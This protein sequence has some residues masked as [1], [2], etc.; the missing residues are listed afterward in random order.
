MTCSEYLFATLSGILGFFVGLSELANRYKSFRLLLLDKYSWLYMM[1]NFFGGFIVYIIVIQ[2][3]LPIGSLK[4]HHIGRV[5]FCGLSAMAIL[6][7]SFF[8]YKDANGKTFEVGPAALLTIFSKVAEIQFDQA[9]SKKNIEEVES[10][11]SKTQLSFISASKDL[12]IIIMSSMRVLT[13]EEQKLLSG[14]ITNLV[15]DDTITSA[16]KNVTLG[17]ILLKYAGIDLLITSVEKLKKL[18]D[19]TTKVVIEQIKNF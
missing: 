16:V 9:L 17:L 7:S 12:P 4:D 5:L 18:Y 3:N 6:R 15:N 11:M 19:S 13:P 2:Y 8:T 10:I 1:L 14:E